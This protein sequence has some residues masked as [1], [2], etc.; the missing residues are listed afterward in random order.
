MQP[1]PV[2]I[3]F[4]MVYA[5]IAGAVVILT[6]AVK[7]AQTV[8]DKKT[9]G[10]VFR[11]PL[12]NVIIVIASHALMQ[13]MMIGFFYS[14]YVGNKT[15]VWWTLLIVAALTV[16][17]LFLT[18]IC[19]RINI[20]FRPDGIYYRAYF[21]LAKEY[22]YGEI[23]RCFCFKYG[24]GDWRRRRW[25]YVR[26]DIDGGKRKITYLATE[27]ILLALKTKRVHCVREVRYL[28]RGIRQ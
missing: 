22:R 2:T 10:Q 16:A 25:T 1:V 3:P 15:A 19:L 20:E 5:A 26:I 9:P 12:Q 28:Y 7:I 13:G 6:V 27:K 4:I 11:E 14:A 21:G 18:V 24:D 8:S 23:S 17:I